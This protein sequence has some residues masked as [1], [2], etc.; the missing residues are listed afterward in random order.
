MLTFEEL[1]RTLSGYEAVIFAYEGA[2]AAGKRLD[3]VLTGNERTV[4]LIVGP[5]GGFSEG[6]VNALKSAGYEPVTLGKRILR[7][8][9]AAV[10][11]AAVIMYAEGEWR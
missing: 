9:T 3:D 7:A 2:Y 5:E 4:A 1:I 8:E 6:E 10:A 11:A